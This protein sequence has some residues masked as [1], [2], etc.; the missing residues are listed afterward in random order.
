M[1]VSV[2]LAAS[3]TSDGSEITSIG[4][5]GS[6]AAETTLVSEPTASTPTSAPERTTADTAVEEAPTTTGTT[7]PGTTPDEGR[8]ANA[9]TVLAVSDLTDCRGPAAEVAELAR[10]LD[11]TILMPGDLAYGEGTQQQ[12][13]DCFLPLYGSELDRI[14]ATPGDNDYN[15]PGAVPYFDTMAGLPGEAGKGWYA[16]E[17]GGWQLISLNS[18][19]DEVGGCR[20]GSEQYQWL[21]ELLEQDQ[22]ECRI[23]MWHEPRFTSAANYS[24]IPRLGDFYGRLHGA[25]ADILLVGHSHHYERLGPLASNGDPAPGG[26]MNF[27]VGVGG[28]TFTEFGD[29]LPGSQVRSNEHRGLVQFTLGDG[30]YDWEFVNAD[31]NSTDLVDS[32][33]ADC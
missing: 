1:L 8:L 7:A 15:T 33:S 22:F 19:C 13:D 18:N 27:T 31:S 26:I 29:P 9:V 17:F 28:A 24:G 25:G 6:S 10:S 16:V 14:Y 30:G 12:F 11:G 32:G 20:E 5:A 4:G 2:V 23:V 3:C 21:D